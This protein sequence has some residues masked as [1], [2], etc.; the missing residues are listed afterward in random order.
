M[1]RSDTVIEMLRC[2]DEGRYDEFRA[3]LDPH[4][5]WVNPMVQAQGP[6]EIV[7]S[8]AAY[9]AAFPERRHE[10]SLV[11]EVGA[12]VAVEGEWIATHAGPLATPEGELPATGRTVRVPF[13]AV[14]RVPDG[15]VDSVHV[16]LDPL[17][18]M[19]Q[20]GLA[21]EPAAA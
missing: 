18:F 14:I 21:P 4:C 13:A 1:S 15:R 11:L 20:L 10:L 6:D 7:R 3:G 12:T 19:A 8:L 5:E 9:G 16:Y 2:T 17:G